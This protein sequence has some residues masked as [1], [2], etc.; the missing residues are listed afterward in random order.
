MR[1]GMRMG[2]R[3]TWPPHFRTSRRRIRHPAPSASHLGVWTQQAYVK[4]SNTGEND[5]FGFSVALS[6][7]GSRLLVGAR[8]ESSKATG[9]NGDQADDSVTQ[10]GAVYAFVRHAQTWSQLA[11][12]KA[13][14]TDPDDLFGTSVALSGDG[15]TAAVGAPGEASKALGVNGDQNDDSLPGAGAVYVLRVPI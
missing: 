1:M 4:A 6:E 10:A 8:N 14:N 11:Y 13:S 7:D 15:R 9:I 3:L 12:V 2:V 5:W